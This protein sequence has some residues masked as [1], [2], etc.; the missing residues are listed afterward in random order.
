LGALKEGKKI[1]GDVMEEMLD[2]KVQFCNAVIDMY[3][4]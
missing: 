1:H 4:K 2:M 3:A